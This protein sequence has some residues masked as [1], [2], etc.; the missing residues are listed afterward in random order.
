MQG[1]RSFRRSYER[2]K[3]HAELETEPEFVREH[4]G[5]R[6][7]EPEQ[8]LNVRSKTPRLTS[9]SAAGASMDRD[10]ASSR[11]V[12]TEQDRAQHQGTFV[13]PVLSFSTMAS[14]ADG[15]SPHGLSSQGLGCDSDDLDYGLDRRFS[16]KRVFAKQ[17]AKGAGVDMGLGPELMRELSSMPLSLSLSALADD[18]SGGDTTDA[19]TV[20]D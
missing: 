8:G 14:K 20:M 6:N 13:Q 16:S 12:H 1:E 4:E 10:V 5:Q 18:D 17:N 11:S 15:Q 9:A 7:P 19:N 3:V 2:V